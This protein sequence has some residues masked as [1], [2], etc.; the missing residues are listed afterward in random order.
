MG[1][2]IKNFN[3]M[4]VL[5]KIRFLGGEGGVLQKDNIQ[6]GGNCLKRSR[7]FGKLSD[8]RGEVLAKKRRWCF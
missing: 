1:L 2:R 5:L 6:G 3:I 4:W 7:E 8:L